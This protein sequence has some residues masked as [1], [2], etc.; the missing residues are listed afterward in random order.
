M[1]L[2]R[3]TGTIVAPEKSSRFETTKL[4]L[5]HPIG[6]DGSLLDAAEDVAVDPGVSAGVGDVVLV[7]KE[8]SAVADLMDTDAPEG[9]PP[10]PANVIILAVVDGWSTPEA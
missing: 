1:R 6:L 2:C 10:T 9:T 5:V 8:G 7:A 3:V 4:L